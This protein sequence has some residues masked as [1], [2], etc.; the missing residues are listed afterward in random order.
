MLAV[1][2]KVNNNESPVDA[3]G[4]QKGRQQ[5]WSTSEIDDNKSSKR[6]LAVK[7]E[8]DETKPSKRWTSMTRSMKESPAS[9][10]CDKSANYKRGC[11]L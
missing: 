6:M 10:C 5:K 3:G 2:N 8:V 4:R 9:G 11:G 1:D 7:D